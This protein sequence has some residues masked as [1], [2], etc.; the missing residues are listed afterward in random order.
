MHMLAV[1]YL[2][3][4]E[5]SKEL[6]SGCHEGAVNEFNCNYS[7]TLVGKNC[8]LHIQTINDTFKLQKL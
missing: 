7:F 8:K 5:Q 4:T 6:K 2:K 1:Y 3:Q